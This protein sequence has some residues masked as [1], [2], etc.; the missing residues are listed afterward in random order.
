[1]DL[2]DICRTF[3]PIIVEC[4]LYLEDHGTLYKRDHILYNAKI[5]TGKLKYFPCILSDHCRIR[6]CRATA[7]ETLEHIQTHED[8]T[9]QLN[10]ERGLKMEIKTPLESSENI[11]YQQLWD[12]VKAV[13]ARQ[14]IATFMPTSRNQRF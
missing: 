12:I 6:P 5:N 10:D 4:M 11:T 7:R 1:M 2:I 8:Y 14:V 13:L 3:H 9:T